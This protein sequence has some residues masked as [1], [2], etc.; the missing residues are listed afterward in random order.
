[1]TDIFIKRPVLSIVVS[2]SSWWSG[3][4]RR[5]FCRC[6]SF[7]ATQSAN[8][9]VTTIYYGADPDVVAGFITAPIEQAVSQADGIDFVTSSSDSGVSQVTA[10]L[11][12]NYDYN[13]AMTEISAKVN[14]VLNTLPPQAQQPIVT[15]NTNESV[16]SIYMSFR[17]AVLA[18][19]PDERL[20]RA[21][22]QAGTG[23]GA[24]RAERPDQRPAHLRDA[25]VAGPGQARRLRT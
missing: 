5:C 21:H 1:M 23:I 18:S 14:A 8:I 16:T 4:G 9:S 13:K 2:L 19:Q 15:L 7:R 25:R 20:H 24:G 17:S 11:R 12:L 6:A 10:H 3:C 22:H